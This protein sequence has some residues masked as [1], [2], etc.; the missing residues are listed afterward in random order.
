[1]DGM[2]GRSKREKIYVYIQLIHFIVQQKLM[3]HCKAVSYTPIKKK[4]VKEAAYW[5][6]KQTYNTVTVIHLLPL[7]KKMSLF[8]PAL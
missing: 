7:R 3:Q 5:Y 6:L 8:W 2:G 1:M 4:W